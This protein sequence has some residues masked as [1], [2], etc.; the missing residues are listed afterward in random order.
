MV[1]LELSS[2][3]KQPGRQQA[4]HGRPS[5]RASACAATAVIA[6][7]AQDIT[8]CPGARQPR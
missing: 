7:S 5:L 8:N 1:G 6:A 4:Y 3:M 2:K